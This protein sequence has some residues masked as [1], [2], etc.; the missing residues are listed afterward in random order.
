MCRF[1]AY[2]GQ[3]ILLANVLIKPEDSLLQQSLLAKETASPTNGDGFGMGWYVPGISSEPAVFRSVFPA[4]NDENLL[5]LSNKIKSSLFF[6]HVRSAS[7]GGVNFYNCH[8]FVYKNWMLM[9]NG[10]IQDFLAIKRPLRHLLDDDIYHWIRGGT[11]S[12]HFFALF[13]QLAKGKDLSQL[14]TVTEVLESTFK[15]VEQLINECGTPGPSYYNL[16]LTDGTRIIASRYCTDSS[17]EPES[18]HY[19]EGRYFWSKEDCLEQVDL[20]PQQSVVISS[21]ALTDFNKQWQRVPANHF[22]TVDVDYSIQ[23][24][25]VT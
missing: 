22:I 2:T 19:L 17:I 24:Q 16:C 21:E 9:H 6:S 8:P 14:L 12:E 25:P 13:L 3:D 20:A 23:I 7:S 11:D 1:I 10:Q 15:K 18:L 5:H 4:W